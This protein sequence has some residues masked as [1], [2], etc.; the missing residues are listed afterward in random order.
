MGWGVGLLAIAVLAVLLWRPLRRFSRD[1]QAERAQELFRLQRPLLEEMFF[2]AAST[3][4]KPRGLRWLACEW[5]PTTEFARERQ[6][7]HIAALVGVTLHFEALPDSDMEGLP[8]VG[9]PR[10]A[11]AV[12]FFHR[13]SWQ[14]VGEARMNLNP[15]E[16]LERFS[17]RY[18]RLPQPQDS[19][20]ASA[21][22]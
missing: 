14:T 20:P 1:V 6:T 18:E 15:N 4:G 2:R 12:F 5:E 17:K 9:L 22:R 10:N 8:A 13:G 7:G 11:T 3:S 21:A 16:I 19:S